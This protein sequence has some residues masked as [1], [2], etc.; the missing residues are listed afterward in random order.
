MLSEPQ[1][2]RVNLSICNEAAVVADEGLKLA[3][4]VITLNPV[5]HE[6]TVT[7]S[8]CYA[9]ICVDEVKV[10]ADVFPAFDQVIIG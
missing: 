1:L 10:V 2:F 6:S 8:C 9:V 3:A 7:G 4:Q 5:D